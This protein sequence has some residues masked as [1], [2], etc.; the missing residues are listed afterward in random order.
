MPETAPKGTYAGRS[1]DER[2]ADRRRRFLEAALELYGTQGYAAATTDRL[3]EAAGLS[4]RQF[5]EE[6]TNRNQLLLELYDLI[7]DEASAAVAVAMA[8]ALQREADLWDLVHEGVQIYVSANATDVRRAQ[9]AYVTI[10]G[11]TPEIEEHRLSRRRRWVQEMCVLADELVRRGQIPDRDYRLTLSAFVGA[12]NGLVHDW[13]R[14]S[15]RPPLAE[16]TGTLTHLL[17]SS[18]TIAPRPPAETNG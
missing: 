13:C 1:V 4:T 7:N 16:I 11:V 5:Y 6:F 12:V 8:A 18:L 9:V 17:F 2:R 10:V 14:S 3:C 15:P